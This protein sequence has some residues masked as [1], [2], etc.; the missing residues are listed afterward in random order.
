MTNYEW[1]AECDAC[2]W[3]SAHPFADVAYALLT[4]HNVSTHADT[5]K[6]RV[7]PFVIDGLPT[8]PDISKAADNSQ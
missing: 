1:P 4:Q 5:A 2:E 3:T 7:I 6:G 8:F